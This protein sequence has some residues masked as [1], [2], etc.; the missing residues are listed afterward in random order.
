MN[1][2]IIIALYSGQNQYFSLSLQYVWTYVFKGRTVSFWT[3]SLQND[4][5]DAI[6]YFKDL[7]VY[8]VSLKMLKTKNINQLS[9]RMHA[10][11]C[12]CGLTNLRSQ[13]RRPSKNRLL[14]TFLFIAG[15]VKSPKDKFTFR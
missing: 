5:T 1:T 9:Q 8:I 13:C 6:V 12:S 2:Q 3:Y 15:P 4:P 14:K 10:V 11:L 7:L